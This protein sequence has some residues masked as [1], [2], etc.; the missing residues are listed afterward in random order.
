MRITVFSILLYIGFACSTDIRKTLSYAGENKDELE[1]V[2]Q[3]YQ[4]EDN[5]PLKYKAACFLIENMK[6]YNYFHSDQLPQILEDAVAYASNIHIN[7]PQLS[8]YRSATMA[9]DSITIKHGNLR[10][11]PY[12]AQNDAQTI[13]ADFLIKDIDFSFK[14]WEQVPWGKHVSFHEFCTQILPYRVGN[15]D[16]SI[17]RQ[18]YY[19]AFSSIIDSL[20][21]TATLIDACNFLYKK[22][23]EKQWY[24]VDDI[25]TPYVDALSLLKYRYGGCREKTAFMLFAMR[26]LCI[27][28]SIDMFLQTPNKMYMYHYWNQMKDDQGNPIEFLIGDD[29]LTPQTGSRDTTRRRG[30]IYRLCA[31]IQEESLSFKEGYENIPDRLKNPFIRNVSSEY[32]P[33]SKL[34]IDV[35]NK[36]EKYLYLCLFNNKEWIPVTYAKINDNQASYSG[37]EQNIV[38]LPAYFRNKEVIP[39]SSPFLLKE[40][41]VAHFLDPDTTSRQ[42]LILERKH[43]LPN[44][45]FHLKKFLVGGTFEVANEAN[46]H[47]AKVIHTVLDD[48]ELKRTFVNID[49]SGK[50]RYVRYVSAKKGW[51][52]M[53]ELSFYSEDSVEMTGKPMG[54]V[55]AR[56]MNQERTFHAVFDKDPLTFFEAPTESGGWVGLDFGEPKQITQIEF[57][58]RNDDNLIRKGDSYE[59]FYFSGENWKSAGKQI[60]TDVHYLIYTDMPKNSLFLLRN[61]TRGREERIF[62]YENEKQVFW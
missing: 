40:D 43:P 7:N 32:Y 15:E 35:K 16:V 44:H 2:L 37:L 45:L 54:M 3:H 22:V 36:K 60:G 61:H 18:E 39:A 28:G 31:D 51:C 30:V 58:F 52:N 19:E 9:L 57:Q 6:Y 10:Y 26:S 21:A 25:G 38:Y 4:Y 12:K 42:N 13:S 49:I 55:G 53:A 46:F 8:A 1:K 23:Q 14:T 47:D 34:T 20:P 27:P 41:G 50:Y 62:T 11:L 59:L 17:W 5:N 29:H 24:H 56:N 33:E 48:N